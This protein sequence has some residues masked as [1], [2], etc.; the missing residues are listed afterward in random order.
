MRCPRRP[1]AGP[2]RLVQVLVEVVLEVVLDVYLVLRRRDDHV[3]VLEDPFSLTFAHVVQEP[4][5]GLDDAHPSPG[6]AGA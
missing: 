1:G 2:P 5:R 4:P 6:R 3:V